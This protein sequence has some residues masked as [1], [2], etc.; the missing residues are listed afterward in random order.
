MKFTEGN[1]TKGRHDELA[2]NCQ[3]V[4]DL[5]NRKLG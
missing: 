2:I 1:H 3:T 5:S 4:T